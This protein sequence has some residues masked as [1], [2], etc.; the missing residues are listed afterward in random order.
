MFY[1]ETATSNRESAEKKFYMLYLVL[2]VFC[3]V[4]AGILIFFATSFIPTMATDSGLTTFGKI[5]NIGFLVFLII[6]FLGSGVLLWFIKKRFNVSYDYSFVE[7]ELRIT[8]IFNGRS[9][10]FF[11]TIRT[12]S[13]LRIGWCEKPSYENVLRGLHGKPKF[14]TPNKTPAEEKEFIYI[15]VGGSLE[16]SLYVLE[17]R[18]MLLEYLVQSAGINKLERE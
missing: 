4:V 16:K 3:F 14:L 6:A 7:D 10:K 2:S 15:L 11:T 18:R 12:D 1:E 17:C 8:K 5:F 9:R 13:I